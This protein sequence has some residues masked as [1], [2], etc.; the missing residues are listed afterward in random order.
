MAT[1]YDGKAI[2]KGSMLP[3]G[4]WGWE[5]FGW[6]WCYPNVLAACCPEIELEKARRQNPAF[7]D[8]IGGRVGNEGAA[9]ASAIEK[10]LKEVSFRAANVA[11]NSP[12][13]LNDAGPCMGPEWE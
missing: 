5:D 6:H 2:A 12:R 11:E 10:N 3:N 9:Q 8:W 4:S 13:V 7:A 1:I